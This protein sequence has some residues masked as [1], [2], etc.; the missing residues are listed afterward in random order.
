MKL[1]VILPV[2]NA[3]KYLTEC[4]DSL[5]AQTFQDF[6][7]IAIND[8]STD[9]SGKLLE[10]YAIKESRL[11]VF[12]FSHNQGDP[13]ATQ[14][15]F[16]MLEYMQVDYVARMDA[17][18][19]CLPQRFEKQIAFLEQHPEIDVVGSNMIH[20][21]ENIQETY[22]SVPLVDGEIKASLIT[23]RA[24]ILNPTSMW[25]HSSVK[26]LKLR[27]DVQKIACDFAMWVSLAIYHKKFANIEEPLLKYRLH[28][29]QASNN[30]EQREKAV[31]AILHRYMQVLFPELSSDECLA[32]TK[33]FSMHN[34]V[35]NLDKALYV[36]QAFYKIKNNKNSIIGENR[37][38]VIE[39]FNQNLERLKDFLEQH[40]VWKA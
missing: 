26:P 4:L 10:E 18:D 20:F 24:N 19:I 17:D 1:A 33:I 2:Y 31:T 21:G 14:F 16:D 6:C 28:P 23:A 25:R 11:R 15:A 30:T 36:Y 3:E 8:A 38:T 9:S 13:A 40:N 29:S 27:Y 39:I 32:L 7:V 5:F 35:L 22:T 34:L 12:H 37:E